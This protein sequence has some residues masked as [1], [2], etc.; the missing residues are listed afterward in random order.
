MTELALKGPYR[1]KIHKKYVNPDIINGTIS[2]ANQNYKL[3]HNII[4][5]KK[6][7]DNTFFIY[8]SYKTDINN[9]GRWYDS[10]HGNLNLIDNI[11]TFVIDDYEIEND[12]MPV[13]AS[14]KLTL[15]P[16]SVKKL[17]KLI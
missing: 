10:K 6:N 13:T 8:H 11:L 9:S 14:I 1:G 17:N 4:T 5:V 3:L 15:A 2:Y 16:H 7:T 12:D